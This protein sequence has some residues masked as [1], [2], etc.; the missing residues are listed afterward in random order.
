MR[1]ARQ[2]RRRAAR[3]GA[4]HNERQRQWYL[5]RAR[6]LERGFV[7][8]AADCCDVWIATLT[9]MCLGCGVVQERPVR[10]G[11][12]AWCGTCASVYRMRARDRMQRG[13]QT[14]LDAEMTR[15][16]REG[17]RAGCRPVI[18]LVTLTVKHSGS[19]AAD[20]HT[21]TRGWQRLRA[22]LWHLDEGRAL[23]FVL[24]W[25]LTPGR[26]GLGHVHA[27][28]AAIWPWRDLRA[29]DAEWQRVTHGAGV[30]VDVTQG[31]KGTRRA[32]PVAAARYVSTYVEAG[33]ASADVPLPMRAEW[34]RIA[35]T[36]RS[37]TASRGLLP[38]ALPAPCTEA[39]CNGKQTSVGFCRHDNR[40]PGGLGIGATTRSGSGESAA[41]GCAYVDGSARGDA[42]RGRA[43]ARAGPDGPAG[44]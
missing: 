21:I 26:D 44:S 12:R 23:P 38:E 36:H 18:T 40:R 29:I 10:C 5:V 24:A 39:G 11:L 30:T 14:A 13:L 25:E 6:A 34:L 37:Y 20:R 4:R 28:V 32:G 8:R 9:M 1:L 33:G 16:R 19:L 22:W 42:P 17:A 43:D 31:R 15:W 41:Y 27:H 2:Y 35:R 3:A 7:E